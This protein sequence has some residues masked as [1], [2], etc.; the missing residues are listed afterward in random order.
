MSRH[1]VTIA[2]TAEK[3]IPRRGGVQNGVCVAIARA[4]DAI[5]R[6]SWYH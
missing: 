4:M 2:P 6:Y 1:T 5:V 3:V